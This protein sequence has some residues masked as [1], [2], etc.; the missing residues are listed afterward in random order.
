VVL[1]VLYDPGDVPE[2]FDAVVP[3][4][5]TADMAG[6]LKVD[7]DDCRDVALYAGEHELLCR[8]AASSLARELIASLGAEIHSYVAAIGTAALREDDPTAQA[9]S[10][11]PLD[12]ETSEVRCPSPQ[13][14]RRM[15][16]QID[17]AREEG[18]TLGGIFRVVATGLP[19]G[20]GATDADH[21][22]AAGVTAAVMGVPNVS[23]VELGCGFDLAR[24]RG[25]QYADVIDVDKNEGFVR[26]AN[27]LGGIEGGL[28]TGMPLV[29]SAAVRPGTGIAAH[30][31]SLNM[32]QLIPAHDPQPYR[33]VCTVPQLA[34]V[35][36]GEMAFVLANAYMDKFGHD[37]LSE[38]RAGVQSYLQRLRIAAR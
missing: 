15:V 8:V 14:T 5:G 37:S 28:T 31:A 16:A 29:V 22:L 1:R 7:T 3:R 4:S 12:I 24:Q 2:S 34:V 10:Y 23:G 27:T 36:E 11:E 38:I 33:D 26:K 30:V 35:A 21:N 19:I 17:K 6:A 32:E 20:L 9:A 18:D 13:V 25:S